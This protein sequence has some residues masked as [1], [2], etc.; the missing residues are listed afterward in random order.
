[1]FDVL[2]SALQQCFIF[3]PLTLGIYISYRIIRVTDLTPDGTFVLG[4]AIYA[5]CMSGHLPES[6]ALVLAVAGGM[7]IGVIVALMQRYARINSLIASILAVF[8]L[9]SVNFAVMNR[10]NISLLSVTTLINRIQLWGSLPTLLVTGGFSLLLLVACYALIKSP[11]GLKL[12][13]F[14][15]N[16]KLLAKLG[17]PPLLFLLLGLALANGLAA[18]CGSITAQFNGYADINMGLGTALT[19]IGAVVIGCQLLTSLCVRDQR[20]HPIYD[21]V[22]CL[23]GTYLY[24]LILNL[25]LRIGL[26]PIYLKLV[27]GLLLVVFLSSANYRQSSGRT[28]LLELN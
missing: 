20:Y 11:I 9:Y 15:S 4:A 6:L 26:N 1:M 18:L 2:L 23:V 14:G 16:R 8:M 13:A 27:L 17:Q 10:P 25:F 24:Y 28:S 3:L 12:R 5:R 19:G 7:L 22:G 21:L